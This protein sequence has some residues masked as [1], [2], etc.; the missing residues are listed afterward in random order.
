MAEKRR[1]GARP[2]GRDRI[3]KTRATLEEREYLEAFAQDRNKTVSLIVREA[4][5]A[6]GALPPDTPILDTGTLARIDGRRIR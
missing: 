6:F 4:L 1:R 5:I 3:I 2:G